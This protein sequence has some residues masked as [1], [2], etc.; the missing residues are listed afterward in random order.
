M[1]VARVSDT[2]PLAER[3][4]SVVMRRVQLLEQLHAVEV[5]ESEID[6]AIEEDQRAREREAAQ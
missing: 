1:S 3:K 6:T 5:A 2:R 4:A